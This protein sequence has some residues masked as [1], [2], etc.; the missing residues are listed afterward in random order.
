MIFC[1]KVKQAILR[2]NYAHPCTS[3][4]KTLDNT[5]IDNI[6]PHHAIALQIAG[7]APKVFPTFFELEKLH[8]KN[9]KSDRE[10]KKKAKEKNR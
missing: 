5:T 8:K 2:N 3:K 10:L 7:I 9:T 1:I 6:Y 4:S